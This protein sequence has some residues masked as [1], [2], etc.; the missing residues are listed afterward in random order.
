MVCHRSIGAN[1]VRLGLDPESVAPLGSPAPGT[2]DFQVYTSRPAVGFLS[3]AVQPPSH[4]YIEVNDVLQCSIASSLAGEV[5]TVSYRILKPT[6]EIVKGQFRVAVVTQRVIS[7]NTEPLPEGFLL[8]ISCK[9]TL[10]TTRGQTFVR[11]FLTDQSFGA[12]QPSA[13][14]LAD[15][16]TNSLAPGFP[17]GRVLAPT[18]GP[19]SLATYAAS[20]PLAGHE[21]SITLPANTRWKVISIL[22]SLATSA[23]VANRTPGVFVQSAGALIWQAMPQG[24][25]A[26]AQVAN[27]SYSS[28]PTQNA[29]SPLF[30]N[31]ALPSPC[32]LSGTARLGSQ[33]LN[34]DAADQYGAINLLVEEWLDNV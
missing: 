14:L 17:Y 2:D 24:A 5:V 32:Y 22:A 25:V 26:A 34:I 1:M 12:N 18:E 8:S 31:N 11:M 16:V 4:V 19:G 21:W 33:T 10:A 13:M 28:T 29:A 9:A 6:G 3:K 15:Y 27:A 30:L 20:V 7:S 23:A